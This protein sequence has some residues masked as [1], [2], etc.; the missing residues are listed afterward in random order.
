MSAVMAELFEQVYPVLERVAVVLQAAV[1]AQDSM[2][3]GLR[4]STAQAERDLRP[5][6]ASAFGQ[7][8][9]LQMD[10]EKAVGPTRSERRASDEEG[11]GDPRPVTRGSGLA[12][13]KHKRSKSGKRASDRSISRKPPVAAHKRGKS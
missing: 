3:E 4:Q 8:D 6:L 11:S 9:L 12:G 7:L 1:R 5:L 2:K 10:F 13:G